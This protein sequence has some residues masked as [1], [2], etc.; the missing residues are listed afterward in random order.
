MDALL[1]LAIVMVLVVV[2]AILSLCCSS[3]ERRSME[4]ISEAIVKLIGE[5]RLH[6]AAKWREAKA[7][8]YSCDHWRYVKPLTVETI[9]DNDSDATTVIQQRTH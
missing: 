5:H 9:L 3:N 2:S 4:K 1:L 6:F 8:L 7:S